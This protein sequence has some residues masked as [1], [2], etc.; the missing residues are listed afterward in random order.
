MTNYDEQGKKIFYKYEGV[1]GYVVERFVYKMLSENLEL[2]EISENSVNSDGDELEM[3]DS[4][5]VEYDKKG[6]PLVKRDKNG[7]V[8]DEWIIGKG[9]DHIEK[10]YFYDDY[11]IVSEYDVYDKGVLKASHNVKDGSAR[12]YNTEYTGEKKTITGVFEINNTKEIESIKEYKNNKL[13]KRVYSSCTT[14]YNENED[15]I[16]TVCTGI[17]P[18]SSNYEYVYDSY[19]NWVVKR[20]FDAEGICTGITLRRILYYDDSEASDFLNSVV[21]KYVVQKYVEPGTPIPHIPTVNA[22]VQRFKSCPSCLGGGLC[23]YC[24]GSGIYYYAGGQTSCA[25][26]GGNGKCSMCA[27]RGGEYILEY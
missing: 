12:T 26:C 5:T 13:T 23:S 19:G 21:D 2:V 17:E 20:K 8:I 4:Y 15:E 27:G 16:R 1:D 7:R 10:H 24:N 3:N 11:P 6:L 22:P 9:R 25:V 14:Y 18:H